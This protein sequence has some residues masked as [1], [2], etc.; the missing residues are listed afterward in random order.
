MKC[1]SCGA[2]LGFGAAFCPKCGTKV[3]MLVGMSGIGFLDNDKKKPKAVVGT[4][5]AM[6]T[7]AMV[8]SIGKN[9]NNAVLL[10]RGAGFTNITPVGL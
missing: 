3:A 2:S 7:G 4:N 8:D 6:I 9:Y 5:Q 10:F 1:K